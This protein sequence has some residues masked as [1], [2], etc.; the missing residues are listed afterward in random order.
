[1]KS[2]TFGLALMVIPALL[3]AQQVSAGAA[4]SA[5]ANA[6]AQTKPIRWQQ[7][8]LASGTSCRNGSTS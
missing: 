2:T 8:P 3:S 7:P 1:M 6:S 4:A 5:K